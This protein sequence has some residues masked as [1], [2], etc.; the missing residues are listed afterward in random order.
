MSDE[1]QPTRRRRVPVDWDLLEMALTWHS[2]E[3]RHFLDLRTGEVRPY[4]SFSSGAEREDFEL[5]ED[6]AD[7]GQAEGHLVRVEPIESSVE[8]DWM[9]QFADSVRDGRLR[10]LLGVALGGR[11]AFRR[12]KDVLA[13][14][15]RERERWFR[16]HDER[17]REAMR[18]W[19]EDNDIEPTTEPPE[20]PPG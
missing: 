12:F 18:E 1:R 4:R 14:H 13:G 20:R 15:P 10:E 2:D 9:A 5:S 19:L 3:L 16:F 8:Y 11:G 6:E 7:E 17:V